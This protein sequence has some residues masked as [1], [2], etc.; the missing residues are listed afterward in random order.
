MNTTVERLEW[1]VKDRGSLK[2]VADELGLLP[3]TVGGHLKKNRKLNRRT[4]RKLK[5]SNNAVFIWAYTGKG[6]IPKK[7]LPKLPDDLVYYWERLEWLAKQ[8]GSLTRLS[9]ITGVRQS[10]LYQQIKNRYTPTKK[11]VMKIAT[12]L[13][14]SPDWLYAGCGAPLENAN[15]DERTRKI[16]L[17]NLNRYAKY[18][19]DF[20]ENFETEEE[21]ALAYGLSVR[22]AR[23]RIKL[24]KFVHAQQHRTNNTDK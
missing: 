5:K 18:Y 22:T 6:A 3:Q 1:L 4:L 15:L 2:A 7:E 9:K 16:H 24:G 12:A 11:V 17:N 13:N 21:Y 19:E 20:I 23:Y 10:T 14:L 8:K